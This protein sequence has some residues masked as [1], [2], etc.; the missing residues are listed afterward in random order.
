MVE[1]CDLLLKGGHIIDPLNS[2]DGPADLA[3]RC[4]R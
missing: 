2:I 3:I 1:H 4:R